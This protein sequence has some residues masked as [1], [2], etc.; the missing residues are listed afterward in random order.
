MSLQS[1]VLFEA[2]VFRL[3]DSDELL[4]AWVDYRGARLK[5][6]LEMVPEAEPG[7]VVLVQGRVAISRIEEGA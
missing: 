2:R 5:I 4:A 6:N 3:D 1:E 7:D